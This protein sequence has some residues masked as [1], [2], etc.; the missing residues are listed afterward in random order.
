MATGRTLNKYGR[1]YVD[2][3][4]LSGHTRSIGPLSWTFQEGNDDP[5]SA[6][7]VGVWPGQ[8]TINPGTLNSLFDTTQVTGMHALMASP[9]AKRNLLW[10]QGI[11]A[12]PAQ[13]DPAFCGQ[14]QQSDYITEPGA[15]PSALTIKFASNS[16]NSTTLDYQQPWGTLLH[17]NTA[18]TTDNAAV[19]VDDWG[20]GTTDGG[21]MM[22]QVTTAAG[23]GNITGAIKVQD[24]TTNENADFTDLLSTGTINLGSGGVAVPTSGVVA[25]ATTA[26]VQR[27]IRWQLAW[28]LATSITFVLA[29]VRGRKR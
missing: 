14:F 6:D 17:A 18:A 24:A 12:V 23:A 3:Y 11:R 20:A 4:D 13:G 27:Y 16:G 25:L 29:F 5:I 22:Y 9:P 1:I 28:T 19:G 2:G 26:T 10:A 7:I 21:Y 15:T 8:A